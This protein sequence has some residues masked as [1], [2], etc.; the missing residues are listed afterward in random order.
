MGCLPR[1]AAKRE[2]RHLRKK[3][4][5]SIQL[6]GAEGLN[7]ALMSDM[8]IQILDFAQLVF[9]LALLHYILSMHFSFALEL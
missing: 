2:K 4:F 5:K 8:E 3:K 7:R 1:K 9:G 6:K